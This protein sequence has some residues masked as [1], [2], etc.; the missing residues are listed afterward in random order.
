MDLTK[1]KEALRYEDT[2]V[3]MKIADEDFK[4]NVHRSV[5]AAKFEEFTEIVL[6]EVIR[7]GVFHFGLVEPAMD[8]ATL[9][10]FTDIDMSQFNHEEAHALVY[11][12][13]IIAEIEKCVDCV[14]LYDLRHA[15]RTKVEY[16]LGLAKPQSNSEHAYGL[17][18]DLIAKANNVFDIITQK[19]ETFDVTDDQIQNLVNTMNDFK[20][21]E[22]DKILDFV[23][24]KED[25]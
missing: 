15:A 12:T 19:A 21:I 2:P 4:F 1:I 14:L 25:N 9:V 17:L 7:D 20:G 10:V 11:T 8:Y 18:C 16:Y 22:E 23:L 6:A 13:G 3:Q 5:Q 24:N